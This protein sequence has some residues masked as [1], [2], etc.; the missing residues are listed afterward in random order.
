M[1]L[2]FLQQI[3][4]FWYI[5]PERANYEGET[6]V[7]QKP[8]GL[9]CLLETEH[10]QLDIKLQKQEIHTALGYMLQKH[11]QYGVCKLIHLGLAIIQ[12]FLTSSHPQSAQSQHEILLDLGFPLEDQLPVRNCIIHQSAPSR[13]T[14]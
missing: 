13:P 14:Y 9:H 4:W 6:K 2:W 11:S 3:Y 1:K 12:D 7:A 8:L 5:T 10:A